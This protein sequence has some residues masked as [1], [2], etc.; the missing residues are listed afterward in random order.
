MSSTA[1]N[2]G[3]EIAA[4]AASITVATHRLL[5]LL[6]AFDE[7]EAWGSDG[8]LSCAHWLSWRIG[9]DLGA[10]REKVRVARALGK[11]P[12]IDHA[13]ARAE[14]SYSKVRAVTRVATR[15]ERMRAARARPPRDG[16]ADG[17]A[18]PQV[19]GRPQRQRSGDD[20]ARDL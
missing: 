15:R 16:L 3:D 2:L 9:L 4:L 17:E 1:R 8:A 11:L 5:A 20:D 12:A 19:S 14:L 13:F 6:R 18:V 10:A 7:A